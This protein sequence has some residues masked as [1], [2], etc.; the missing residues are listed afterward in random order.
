MIEVSANNR[1]IEV[2]ATTAAL[3]G[4]YLRIYG[5]PRPLAPEV[6]VSTQTLFAELRFSSPAFASPVQG[7]AQANPLAPDTNV[8]ASGVPAWFRAFAA[9]GTTAVL[10]GDIPDDLDPTI[11]HLVQG[12]S[13]AVSSLLYRRV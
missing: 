7:G 11:Q 8:R 5:A 2:M 9:D 12:G 13:L 3:N 10:D 4:G 1:N 6:P